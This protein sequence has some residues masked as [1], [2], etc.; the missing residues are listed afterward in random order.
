LKDLMITTEHYNE[1]FNGF[2]IYDCA[3]RAKDAYSFILI[4]SKS[5]RTDQEPKKRVVTY[6]KEYQGKPLVSWGQ[7]GYGRK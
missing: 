6:F 4:D 7:Y 2:D 1:A 5:N 3:V